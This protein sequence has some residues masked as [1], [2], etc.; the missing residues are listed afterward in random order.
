[1]HLCVCFCVCKCVCLCRY[2]HIWWVCCTYICLCVCVAA[3]TCMCA[4]ILSLLSSYFLIFWDSVSHLR[5]AH[6]LLDSQVLSPRSPAFAFW[7]WDCRHIPPH[8]ILYMGPGNPNSGSHVCTAKRFTHWAISPVPINSFKSLHNLFLFFEPTWSWRREN[9]H[10]SHFYDCVGLRFWSELPANFWCRVW[11]PV[12]TY[13]M[14]KENDL[15]F[16]VH[17][18]LIGEVT[19]ASEPWGTR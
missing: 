15:R 5:K 7:C 17:Y 11:R 8:Q 3:N 16:F 9:R 18:S 13:F 4:C 6:I 2:T 1:M 12:L 14:T 10:R 19:G